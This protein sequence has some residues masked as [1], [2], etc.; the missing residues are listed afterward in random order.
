M[1]LFTLSWLPFVSRHV[2]PVDMFSIITI[3]LISKQEKALLPYANTDDLDQP[4]Q[5]DQS[6]YAILYTVAIDSVSG[7][8]MVS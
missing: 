7:N 8:E 3:A 1:K 6:M 5:S 2:P 4:A